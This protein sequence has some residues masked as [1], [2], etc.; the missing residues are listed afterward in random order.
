MSSIF[1]FFPKVVNFFPN[2]KL[3]D[4]TFGFSLMD[5]GVMDK[6]VNG[7]KKRKN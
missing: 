7:K 2:K 5:V 6:Q 3:H 1:H 4:T